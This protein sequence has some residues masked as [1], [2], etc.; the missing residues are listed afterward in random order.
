MPPR[1][2][3]VGK[4]LGALAQRPKT[5]VELENATTIRRG[6]LEGLLKILAVDEV[7]QRNGSAWALTGTPW[8]YD[9]KR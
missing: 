4:I 9:A 8:T 1:K 2:S 6:R 3:R 5:L 7:V